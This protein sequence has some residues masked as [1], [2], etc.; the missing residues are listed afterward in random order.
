MTLKNLLCPC[1]DGQLNKEQHLE[2]PNWVLISESKEALGEQV[3]VKIVRERVLTET[4]SVVTV[5]LISV[6]DQD[7]KSVLYINPFLSLQL[8]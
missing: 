5:T 1:L 2:F 8:L 3:Y 4:D 7:P 6:H